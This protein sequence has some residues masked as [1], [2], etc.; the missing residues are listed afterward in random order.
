M[1]TKLLTLLADAP[2]G[3]SV[4]ELSLRLGAQPS[5][6]AGMLETLER[7]GRLVRIGPDAGVCTTC[8]AEAQCQLLRARGAR[9]CVK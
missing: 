6:V 4:T 8:G 7:K 3:L 2:R 5:A 9:Y 1:L